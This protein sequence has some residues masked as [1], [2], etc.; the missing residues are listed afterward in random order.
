MLPVIVGGIVA[1]A[2][3]VWGIGSAV[4][5]WNGAWIRFTDDGDEEHLTLEQLGPWVI[6]RREVPGGHQSYAGLAFFSRL[7]LTR[8]EHGVDAIE[9]MGFPTPI[10][11]KLDGEVMAKLHMQLGVNDEAMAV[12]TP[13]KVEFTHQPPRITS[14][15]FLGPQRRTYRRVRADPEPKR[16]QRGR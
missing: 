9:R 4:F 10:A 3:V 1:A 7:A 5:R 16:P 6:G 13:L 12:F 8:R 2:L 14:M 11:Q 15:S